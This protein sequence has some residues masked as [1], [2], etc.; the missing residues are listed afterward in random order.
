[1]SS[2]M[3]YVLS[4]IYSTQYTGIETY[5][6]HYRLPILTLHI[7]EGHLRTLMLVESQLREVKVRDLSDR[8]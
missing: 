8:N 4:V 3:P 1:M 6:R 7:A 2:T 5:L